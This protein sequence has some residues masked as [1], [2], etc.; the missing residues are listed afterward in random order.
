MSKEL[1][2]LNQKQTAALMGISIRQFQREQ[3]KGIGPVGRVIGKKTYW[4]RGDIK[5]WNENLLKDNQKPNTALRR[6]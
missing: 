2:R 3:F 5:E 4:F 1:N 6:T